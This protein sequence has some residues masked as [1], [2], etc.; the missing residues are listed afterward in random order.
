LDE[1]SRELRR[2]VGSTCTGVTNSVGSVILIDIGPMGRGP[3]QAEHSPEQGWR[4]LLVDS[5]WRLQTQ[6]RVLCD[7]NAADGAQGTLSRCI[8]TLVGRVVT[9]VEVAPPAWDLRVW[10]SDDVDLV[11]FNDAAPDREYS[12][13]VLGTDGLEIVAGPHL[14]PRVQM[15]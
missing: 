7:W 9:K 14:P 3:H 8:S 10:F 2:L 1:V 13:T 4:S 11:V 12:W 6:S 5:P 15:K